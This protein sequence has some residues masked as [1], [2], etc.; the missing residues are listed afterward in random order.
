MRFFFREEN[1]RS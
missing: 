1:T